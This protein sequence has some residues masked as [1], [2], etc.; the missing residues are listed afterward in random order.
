MDIERFLYHFSN[1]F[2]N[3]FQNILAILPYVN[4][5]FWPSVDK[6]TNRFNIYKNNYQRYNKFKNI[7]LKKPIPI[8][9]QI[10]QKK[11]IPVLYRIDRSII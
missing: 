8:F 7:N 3:E 11:I 6:L 1:I 2:I 9:S 10:L 4:K 5:I